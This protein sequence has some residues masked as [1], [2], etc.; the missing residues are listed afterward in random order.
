YTGSQ[1]IK[2]SDL[3]QGYDLVLTSYGIT[4]LDVDILKS[5]HFN[6]IILDESQAIKNPGSIITKAVNN[7]SCKNRLIL[8]GTPVE[9]GTMDLWSQMNFINM[10]LLGSQAIFKKQ[11]LQPIE[12]KNDRVKAS[13]LHAIIKPFIL[14]RMKAQVASDLPEK[15]MQVKYSTMTPDQEDAYQ[16]V[17][18]YY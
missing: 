11:F 13:K 10:G 9:N 7:L 15:V 3:Y 1:R 14:R 8:T 5:F 18:S 6:Y 2:N 17:K 12:K 4:R 16:K